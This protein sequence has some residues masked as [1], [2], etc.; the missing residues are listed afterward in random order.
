MY[1][2]HTN[3]HN[4]YIYTCRPYDDLE[5]KKLSYTF[6]TLDIE[7]K[8]GL[9]YNSLQ[10][11]GFYVTHQKNAIC[12]LFSDKHIKIVIIPPD[13]KIRRDFLF[14]RTDK[15]ILTDYKYSLFAINTIIKFN[16]DVNEPYYIDTLSLYG[17][18]HIL[19][20]LKN[21][22]IISEL[23]Y[24]EQAM[25]NV[26]SSSSGCG[27]VEVLEWWKNSGLPLKYSKNALDYASCNGYVNVLEWW[28][29]SGLPLKYSIDA[30]NLA[31]K[32]G[33]VA[34]LEWWK[35]SRLELKYNE[36][37]IDLA[38]SYGHIKVLDW[39]FNSGLELKYNE[40]ALHSAIRFGDINLVKWWVNSGLELKY[41][42]SLFDEACIF[43]NTNILHFLKKVGLQ[44]KLSDWVIYFVSKKELEGLL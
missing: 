37:A 10:K 16:I 28:K 2:I 40:N 21:I 20:W 31:S 11:G 39:W 26:S 29:N 1:I 44:V 25:D 13:A 23:K 34:V 17:K 4:R 6:T 12:H 3:T 43:R 24:T 27:Y 33:H 5:C 30:L 19:E 38:C 32:Y 15:I 8:P 9:N 41:L 22:I 36:M 42:P 18:L 35:N 14:I 7:L